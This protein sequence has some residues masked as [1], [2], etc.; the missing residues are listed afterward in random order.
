MT[1]PRS[2]VEC[3]RM[4]VRPS[5][6]IHHLKCH[7]MKSA[8]K[9]LVILPAD[10]FNTMIEHLEDLEDI[11][12]YDEAKVDNEPSISIGR[13]SIQSRLNEMLNI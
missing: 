12:L 5:K 3:A 9:Q 2:V 11:R 1:L 13:L 6:K 4:H 7:L 8:G 10:E